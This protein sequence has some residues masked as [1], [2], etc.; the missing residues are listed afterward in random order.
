MKDCIGFFG[1]PFMW[2]YN[3]KYLHKSICSAVISIF[4]IIAAG[5]ITF[6]N[7]TSMFDRKDLTINSYQ[8]TLNKDD[9]F[10][11]NNSNTFLAFRLLDK[12]LMDYRNSF[13]A[14]YVTIRAS[15]PFDS[16]LHKIYLIDCNITIDESY[17]N[18]SW[19][20]VDFNNA[21]LRGNYLSNNSTF[22]V[23]TFSFNYTKFQ[24]D[25]NDTSDQDKIINKFFPL[26][27]F[28]VIQSSNLNLN[29]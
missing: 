9:M 29:N 3:G 21:P 19:L 10:Q 18:E 20:C 27:F 24:K 7:L 6:Y 5:L 16:K 11:L 14:N 25:F 1:E 23:I 13:L 22:V 8:T 15:L 4:I 2:N 26:V 17:S 12:E 28:S